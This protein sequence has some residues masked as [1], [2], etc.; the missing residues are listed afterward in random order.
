MASTKA[1]QARKHEVEVL[2]K[3][4]AEIKVILEK[5]NCMRIRYDAFA[6]YIRH[7]YWQDLDNPVGVLEDWDALTGPVEIPKCLKPFDTIKYAGGPEPMA[8]PPTESELE[9]YFHSIQERK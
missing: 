7:A 1:Y 6:N 5:Y 4:L 2:K 3:E 8:F 9:A